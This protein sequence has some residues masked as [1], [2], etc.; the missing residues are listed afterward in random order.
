MDWILAS[1]YLF[2]TVHN[3]ITV[4]QPVSGHLTVHNSGI[5][6]LHRDIKANFYAN[7]I[8]RY[9]VMLQHVGRISLLH[10][11]DALCIVK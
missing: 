9:I 7:R 4:F 3:S 6:L 1:G 11:R 10:V 8:L 5:T 2:V